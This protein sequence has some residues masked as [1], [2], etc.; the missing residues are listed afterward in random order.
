MLPHGDLKIIL[1]NL[2]GLFIT[3]GAIMLAMAILSAVTGNTGATDGFFYGGVAGICIGLALNTIYPK[4]VEPELRHAMAIA[5]IAYL[6]VPAISSIPFVVTEHM[7]PLDAFFE[8]ISG[9]TGSGFSMIALPENS[10]TLI[11]LWRSVTQWIGGLG[12]ILLMV[13]ILIRPGTST[14]MLYQSE[15]RKDKILPS[16]RSTLNVIWSLY[17]ALT[18]LSLL[19]LLAVGMPAWDALNTALSAISTG[20]FSIY[21]DSVAAYHSLPIEIILLPIMIAGALPFAIIYKAVKKGAF[22]LVKDTQVKAFLLI[23]VLGVVI[24]SIDNYYFYHDAAATIRYSAFQ[25]VSAITCAGFQSVDVSQWSQ[26]AL[27]LM[28]IAM[29]IGG[30]AGSTAGGIKV[31]R[32]IFI[33]NEVK[34][35]LA[36][37]MRS[38]NSVVAVKIGGKRVTEDVFTQE[39]AEASLISFLWVVWIFV[40]VLLLSHIVGAE[41]DLSHIIFAVCSAQGNVG[42]TC[43][44]INPSLSDIGK[45]LVIVN[46]WIGRLEIIPVV[47]LVRYIFKGFG[48]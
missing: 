26:S 6:V 43:G 42:L 36:R 48:N 22:N 2:K 29:V 12:V 18:V 8:A 7:S 38:K 39:M 20:G 19:L 11:Q 46:M 10:N 17:L 1:S 4:S 31:A 14:Y 40:S 30:C 15:A 21:G 44:I 3:I 47:V 24:L 27:L 9:W 41:Y 33:W 45:A 37:M 28:S 23:I 25:Y 13:T 34:L 35:W 32:A 16:I 5:A